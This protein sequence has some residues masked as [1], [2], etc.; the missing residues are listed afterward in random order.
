MSPTWRDFAA[1]KRRR[2]LES[3]P[4][5][6]IINV[7]G[8][9]V[10]DVIGVPSTCWPSVFSVRELQ[11]TGT[12]DVDVLLGKLAAAEW[13]AVEVTAA[14]CR[15]TSWSVNCCCVDLFSL[16][17]MICVGRLIASLRHSSIAPLLA[18]LSSMST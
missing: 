9:D 4:K 3:I 16:L 14:F 10:L 2:Q 1:D 8:E 5:D 17:I 15:R 13:S 11:I 6:W 7:P 18:Q 12:E